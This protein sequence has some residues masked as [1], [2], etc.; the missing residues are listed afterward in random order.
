MTSQIKTVL[1]LGLLTGLIL[2]LGGAM[3]GRTGLVIALVLALAMNV[4][5]Y[6]YSDKIVLAMYRAREVSPS[7]APALHAMVED[8]ARAANLP[9][10][11]VAIL[12]QD[13]PNAFATGR[14][15]EHAVIAVTSGILRLLSS[16][17]LRGVLGHEMGHVRNRDILIQSVAGVLATVVMYVAN[18][19]QFAAIFGLGR[20]DDEE[21]ANPLAALALAIVAPIAA[22]LIQ[23]AISRSREYLADETGARLAGNPLYLASALE[24]LEN[25]ARPA[26]GS[27]QAGGAAAQATAHLFIV[28]P[29][30][31][32]SAASLFSTH[33]PTAERVARLRAM[34][35]A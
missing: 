22:T 9:K 14:D 30:S 24:R 21:G 4:G 12:P 5:S 1:L 8:L 20:S 2:L 29:F 32:A 35:R 10:P 6:W 16:N 27:P 33:P 7:E 11:R 23:M 34:A 18:M 31:G 15:P 26:P 28:N 19:M 25:A 17:E 13:T 3:G